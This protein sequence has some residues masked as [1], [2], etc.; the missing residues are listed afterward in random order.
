MVWSWLSFAALAAD[1]ALPAPVVAP[2]DDW[3]LSATL[4]GGADTWTGGGGPAGEG[5]AGAWTSRETGGAVL[6]ADYGGA[7]ELVA[8]ELGRTWADGHAAGVALRRR[9]PAHPGVGVQ[10]RGGVAAPAWLEGMAGLV[11]GAAPDAS[12]VWRLD[13]G[14]SWRGDTSARA[15]GPALSASLFSPVVP[16]AYV[17]A[18]LD[19]R[20]YLGDA[21]PP[22]LLD[23]DVRVRLL[24][25]G[26]LAFE[27]GGSCTWTAATAEPLRVAGLPTSGTIIGRWRAAGE[28][29]VAGPVS[30]RIEVGGERGA[31]VVGYDRL[32]AFA[33]VV[34]RSASSRLRR[35]PAVHDPDHVRFSV[36]APDA[37]RVEV[38]GTFSEWRPVPL[39]RTPD[40]DWHLEMALLPGTYEYVYLI[41]GRT[42]VPAD[43]PARRED[44]FGGTNGVL[45]V[46]EAGAD[47]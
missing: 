14:A 27:A 46:G 16:G 37:T 12:R 10:A 34:A 9:S 33:G 43:A 39:Q 19:A 3:A 8:D 1:P 17:G 36:R 40:G 20:A 29:G 7:I 22:G 47:D 32:R 21:L 15:F 2:S 25:A 42:T 6:T 18:R 4:L 5:R 41:D 45:L 44:G 30:L 31:G 38:A 35:V 13:A 11:L 28:L 26:R 23:G 24:P